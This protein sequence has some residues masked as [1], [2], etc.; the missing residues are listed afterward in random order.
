MLK[1]LLSVPKLAKAA[2]TN[3][4]TARALID[5]GVVDGYVTDT[6]HRAGDAN[7]VAQIRRHLAAQ[8]QPKH[9]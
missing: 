7:T 5:I 8:K 4:S 3:I 6:G 9:G 1:K 2:G